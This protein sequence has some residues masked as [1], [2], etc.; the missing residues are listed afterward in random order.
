MLLPDPNAKPNV[1]TENLDLLNPSAD[2]L[3]V[4]V[5]GWLDN[6]QTGWPSQ[7]AGAV[8]DRTD[9]NQWLCASYDWKGGSRVV[10]SIMAAEYAR[11]IAGPRL[12][13]AVLAMQR[14]L[15][16]IHL[17]GHSA[18]SWAIHT[19]A[20]RLA[21]RFPE[22]TF[23]LTFLDAYVPSKWNPNELGAIFDDPQRQAKQVWAEQY[24]TRDITYKVTQYS[25]KNAHNVDIT[26]IAPLTGDHEFPYRWYTA[27][28]TGQFGNWAERWADVVF[29][30]QGTTYGF[31]R[32]LEA[33]PQHWQ[34]T[35]TLPMN[36]PAI[37]IRLRE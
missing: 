8:Y 4:A 19:A 11:D 3:F 25:L 7:M 6:G 31:D 10:T 36:N 20:R 2:K 12:A 32:S 9:P 37:V 17:V 27:T 14:P 5:H 22:A 18:G 26:A 30:Y 15:K 23:H 33:G 34:T 21:E 1:I 35:Q 16:H 29:E 13:T 24:Y 28:I